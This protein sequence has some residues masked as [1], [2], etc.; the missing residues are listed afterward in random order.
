MRFETKLIHAGQKPDEKTGSVNVPIYQTS[1]FKQ[2]A[3]GKDRGW[4]YS[5]SSNPTRKALEDCVASLECAESAYAFA[6]GMAAETAVLSL[7]K[8]GERLIASCDIYGGTYRL[9]EKVLKPNGIKVLYLDLSKPSNLERI[10]LPFSMVWLETPSNPLLKICDIKRISLLCQKNKAILS[11]DNTFATPFFQNPLLLGADIC[12]HSSTKYLAGHSDIIGG[13]VAV[14]SKELAKKIKFQQNACGAVPGPWDS[15]LTLRG[16]K[17]LAL[18]MKKHQENAFAVADFL[19]LRK[20]VS[21]VFFTGLKEHKGYYAALKQMK[22]HCGIV[23]FEI[24]GGEK[25]AKKFLSSLKLFSLADSLG[26]VESLAN[27]PRVQTHGFLTEKQRVKL[28][29]TPG[30]IRLSCGIED[31]SDILYDL[32]KSFEKLK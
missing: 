20:E 30:L 22:G 17:T 3:V 8:P 5:R 1:T 26:G 21:K 2:D 4:T 29:I 24:K 13:V 7:L 6:S 28:G 27:Y 18:R 19:K 9:A 31:I 12:V 15:W 25:S 14:K 32:K 10:K 16:I 23:S 11:V